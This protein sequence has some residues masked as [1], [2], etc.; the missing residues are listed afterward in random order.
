M[1]TSSSRPYTHTGILLPIQSRTNDQGRAAI[2]SEWPTP[3]G[4]NNR[5]TPKR[6]RTDHTHIAEDGF[7]LVDALRTG[8]N[9]D[10]LFL[11]QS[12]STGDLFIN[13][14]AQ[15]V[16]IAPLE[17]RVS[18]AG[19]TD[20]PGDQDRGVQGRL[21]RDARWCNQLRFWQKLKEAVPGRGPAYSLYFE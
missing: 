14:I 7:I 3:R 8:G 6:R 13:K 4:N 11:V 19:Y 9:K 17:L 5:Q 16:D 1:S 15:R 2:T 12:V 18:T 10:N 20:V 21:S